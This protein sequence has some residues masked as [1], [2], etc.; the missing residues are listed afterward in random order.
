MMYQKIMFRVGML[1]ALT[2]GMANAFA[3]DAGETAAEQPANEQAADEQPAEVQPPIEAGS[4]IFYSLV[5]VVKFSGQCEVMQPGGVWIAAAEEKF[6][7]LGSIFRTDAG[8]SAV[9][10]FSP[11]EHA[12][13]MES[14]E[15]EVTATG[16]EAKC[17]RVVRLRG[18][19]LNTT[20]RE[21]LPEGSFALEMPNVKC[22]TVEGRGEFSLTSDANGELTR[23]RAVTGAVKAEGYYFTLPTM[24]AANIAEILTAPDRSFTRIT[25]ISGDFTILLEKGAEEPVTFSMTP[26]A[27]VKIWCENAPVGGRP[28]VSTLALSPKGILRHRFAFAVGREGVATGELVDPNAQS[29]SEDEKLPVL[30]AAPD[31]HGQNAKKEREEQE[32][33]EE[34]E[35]SF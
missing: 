32:E 18:G 34:K 22:S 26:K 7:P 11:Q 3:Q 28:I 30:I 27:V 2:F 8:S 9:I 5:R 19:K 15:V 29:K 16:A 23:I 35:E 4:E 13:M 6:Y 1:A 21:N 10:A 24:R 20:L 33:K 25:G 12:Q 31:N 17:C 14:T